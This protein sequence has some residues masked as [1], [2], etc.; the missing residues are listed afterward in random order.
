MQRATANHRLRLSIEIA[1]ASPSTSVRACRSYCGGRWRSAVSYNGNAEFKGSFAEVPSGR[2]GVYVC[3]ERRTGSLSEA[4][5]R[6]GHLP[7][8]S[9][10]A[11]WVR[12]GQ[13]LL[14][15]FPHI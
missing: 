4:P 12:R 3:R 15:I 13:A 14:N 11:V 10:L 1:A 2:T 9:V 5:L 6:L 8:R 7:V